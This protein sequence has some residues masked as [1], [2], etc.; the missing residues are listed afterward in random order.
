MSQ[1]LDARIKLSEVL[2][3]VDEEKYMDV[4]IAICEDN[5]RRRNKACEE[6][7]TKIKVLEQEMAAKVEAEMDITADKY[8]KLAEAIENE[9]KR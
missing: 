2:S 1:Y 8:L 9:K 6:L 5:V 3:T 4:L 7:N